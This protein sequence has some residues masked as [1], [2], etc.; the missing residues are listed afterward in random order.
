MIIKERQSHTTT[1]EKNTQ[2][3]VSRVSVLHPS[4]PTAGY[5]Q[6]R[7]RNHRVLIT[8]T[9]AFLGARKIIL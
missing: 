5:V 1:A 8:A 7:E 2:L 6:A 9:P 3:S 4:I